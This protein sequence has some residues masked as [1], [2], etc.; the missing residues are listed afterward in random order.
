[1]ALRGVD[2]RV[3]ATARELGP[4][5]ADGLDKALRRELV[6]WAANCQGA[7]LPLLLSSL[8]DGLARS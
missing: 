5:S 1:M 7:L 4:C 3:A 2:P 6:D 8:R